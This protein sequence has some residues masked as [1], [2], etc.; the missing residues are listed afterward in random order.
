VIQN[1]DADEGIFVTT[2]RFTEGCREEADRHAIRLIDLDRLLELYAEASRRPSTPRPF[3]PSGGDAKGDPRRVSVPDCMRAA[4]SRALEESVL[5]CLGAAE[6][7]LMVGEIAER[8]GFGLDECKTA[9]ASLVVEGQIEKRGATRGT[10]YSLPASL[11][12]DT[13]GSPID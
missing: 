11:S 3:G 2:S 4:S 7:P 5:T 6:R 9:V 12:S 1:F 8:C 10:R 13:S